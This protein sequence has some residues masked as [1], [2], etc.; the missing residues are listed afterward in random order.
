MGEFD[1]QEVEEAVLVNS[2]IEYVHAYDSA[3]GAVNLKVDARL[4]NLKK[5]PEPGKPLVTIITSTY[6]AA[7]H[8]PTAIKSIREQVYGNFEWI[9]VD[10][11]ST[12]G[13]LD[14]LRQNEDVIDC[15]I[16]EPDKGIYDAW[17]KGLRLARGEWICFVGADDRLLPGAIEAMVNVAN[18]SPAPLDLISGKVQL[19]SGTVQRRIIG[20]PWAWSRFRKYMCVAHVGAI[21]NATYFKRYGEFDSNFRIAGDYE[22]LLRAGP[23]LKAGFVDQVLAFMEIG[24]VSN[25]SA[26]VFR[27]AFRAR[28]KHGA[29]SGFSGVAGP[30]WAWLKWNVRRIINY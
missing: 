13:T 18:E 20:R 3:T 8:L 1:S 2:G 14:I 4:H 6:N 25:Q 19:C 9:I 7:K 26:A 23:N 29:A 5:V 28:L 24:G 27:E 11:A 30:S 17:N 12:D 16:S 15:W 10:G 22:L 21:H